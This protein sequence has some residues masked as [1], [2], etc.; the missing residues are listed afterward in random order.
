[1]KKS[2]I[3]VLFGGVV[4]VSLT[5]I[6]MFVPVIA[7]AQTNRVEVSFTY[8]KQ[9][10]FSSNQF[11]VWIEDAQGRYVKT[12]YATRFTAAGGWQKREQ[13]LP[14]WVKQS[15]LAAMNK[16]QVDALTGPTPKSGSVRYVW[17]GKDSAG[18]PVPAGEYRVLVEATLRGESSVLYTALIKLGERG[19]VKPQ[20]RYSGSDTKERGMIGQ[21]TVS[22]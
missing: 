13:S 1:M 4:L 10:G 12:L 15:N 3:P 16:A 21:V 5:L 14:L 2:Q 6:I 22:Y 19:T 8:T 17:D 11:A 7:N 20:A 18:R 9:G